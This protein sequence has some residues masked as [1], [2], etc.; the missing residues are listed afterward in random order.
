MAGNSVRK[1]VANRAIPFERKHGATGGMVDANGFT[2]NAALEILGVLAYV[3]ED[4]GSLRHA[5]SPE[6]G[7]APPRHPPDIQEMLRK[8]LPV[9]PVALLRRMC[10]KHQVPSSPAEESN[11]YR[12]APV[13]RCFS[14][15]T[16]ACRRPVHFRFVHDSYVFLGRKASSRS[17]SPADHL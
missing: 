16:R 3:V 10:E 7:R 14:H 13:E 6:Y 15:N 12:E 1:E 4:A 2:R 11:P 9:R 5:A 17:N 8:G